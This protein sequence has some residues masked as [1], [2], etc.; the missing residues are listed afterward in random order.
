MIIEAIAP[1][2]RAARARSEAVLGGFVMPRVI[3]TERLVLAPMRLHHISALATLWADPDSTRF[4][5]GVRDLTGTYEMLS[6]FVGH[7]WVHGFG[8]YGI[9]D[10][11][12]RLLGYAGPW[13]PVDKPEIEIVY[14]LLPD[15]R[16]R[17]YGAEAVRAIRAVAEACGAPTLVSYVHPDNAPSRQLAM[18]A[19]ATV[20]TRTTF[21]EVTADVLRYP[22]AGH[23]VPD[24][25]DDEREI[26]LETSA[27]PL[28]IRTRRLTL[29]QWRPDHLERFIAHVGDAETMRFLGGVRT[30]PEA[31]RILFGLAGQWILRG[32]GFYAVEEEGRL[33]GCIG[34]FHPV[35]WPEAELAYSITAD[36]RGRGIAAEAV[37]AVRDVACEQ[38]RTRLVSFIEDEN[39]A[40]LAVAR[41]LGAVREGSIDLSGTIASVWRHAMPDE[42][43][44]GAMIGLQPAE[45]QPPMAH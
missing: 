40:S 30:I 11:E 13:F 38:G 23:P 42:T 6:R 17:G 9:S 33:V 22:C 12:G 14:G 41:R 21:G 32:Y 24:D 37:A 7:W 25:P 26:L 34:L 44:L 39:T 16:G 45:T 3:E 18:A 10:R 1:E 28:T 35:G 20:D 43:R 19:G 8:V 4:I 2:H 31:S 36:S 15:A 29:T 5:G 27:M